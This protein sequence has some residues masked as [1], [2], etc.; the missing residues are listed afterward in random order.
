VTLA[1]VFQAAIA[2]AF[3]ASLEVGGD[4]LG[5]LAVF[6]AG[7]LGL[8]LVMFTTGGRYL[9]AAE[10]A[11]LCMLENILGP[12]W[13]WLFLVENPGLAAVVGGLDVL[14]AL[15]VHTALDMRALRR[16]VPP[17]P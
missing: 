13:V 8:G 6:G 4:D 15:G 1:A 5:L 3:G 17:M 12:L 2:L 10:S 11:L 14:A 16:P 7:Q 9:P